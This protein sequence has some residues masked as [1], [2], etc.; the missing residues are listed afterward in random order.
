MPNISPTVGLMVALLAALS[1][2]A[3]D[4]SVGQPQGQPQTG[5]GKQGY[6]SLP[7]SPCPDIF[8]YLFDGN[9]WFGMLEVPYLDT[10]E[11]IKLNVLL[12][13]QAQLT[14]V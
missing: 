3:C 2:T 11:T 5:A 12:S 13:V 10:Q 8:R 14:T 1:W 7:S 4:R 6:L 9:E